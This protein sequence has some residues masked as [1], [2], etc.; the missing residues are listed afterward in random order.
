MSFSLGRFP[1]RR[2]RRG[3]RDDFTRRLVRQARLSPDDLI[4]PVF[5]REGRNAVEPVASIEPAMVTLPAVRV[6]SFKA[7]RV[8][9]ECRHR[10]RCF[11]RLFKRE[12]GFPAL[13]AGRRRPAPATANV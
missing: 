11:A 4:L 12:S 3:R 10:L 6:D 2:M 13:P 8:P 7:M 9:P 5:V 1:S